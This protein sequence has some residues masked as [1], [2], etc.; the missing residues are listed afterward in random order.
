MTD[1][2]QGYDAGAQQ[3]TFRATVYVLSGM[4]AAVEGDA[5]ITRLVVQEDAESA[6]MFRAQVMD[7]WSARDVDAEVSFG[8]VS[9]KDASYPAWPSGPGR[10]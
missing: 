7:R 10:R 2:G 8:P 5:G 6:E 9:R 1:T 4:A 3:F